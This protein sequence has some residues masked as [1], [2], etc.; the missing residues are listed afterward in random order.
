MVKACVS[1]NALELKFTNKEVKELKYFADRFKKYH[2][3]LRDQVFQQ[4]IR[5]IKESQAMVKKVKSVP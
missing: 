4:Y 5:L 3:E 2:E 1:I